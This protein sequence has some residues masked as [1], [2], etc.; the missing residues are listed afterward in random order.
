V[1]GLTSRRLPPSGIDAF[2]YLC[3]HEFVGRIGRGYR[4]QFVVGLQI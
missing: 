1:V 2:C 4:F 3:Q